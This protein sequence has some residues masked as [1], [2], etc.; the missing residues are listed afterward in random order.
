MPTEGG[1]ATTAE[2]L[3]GLIDA[4]RAIA[5]GE[6]DVEITELPRIPETPPDAE[7]AERMRALHADMKVVE[8][9]LAAARDVA[10]TAIDGMRTVKTAATKYLQA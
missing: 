5:R 2:D 8:Q 1:W 6:T 3:E 7:T 4:W 10:A 9:E